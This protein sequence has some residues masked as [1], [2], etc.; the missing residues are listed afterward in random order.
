VP[1]PRLTRINK[2]MLWIATAFVAAFALFPSYLGS[3]IGTSHRGEVTSEATYD[4]EFSVEGMTCEAC[5]ITLGSHLAS[6]PG[7]ST[8]EVEYTSK[9]ARLRFESPQARPSDQAIAGTVSAAGYRAVL[10]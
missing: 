10:P 2:V 3:L 8:A 1:N 5:A 7:V 9:K 4:L 6:L